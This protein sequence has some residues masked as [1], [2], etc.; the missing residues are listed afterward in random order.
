[1]R[2]ESKIAIGLIMG[3]VAV[4]LFS[5]FGPSIMNAA[6]AAADNAG[7]T[8]RR[9]DFEM[10]GLEA[11]KLLPDTIEKLASASGG[12][13]G[14]PIVRDMAP[15]GAHSLRMVQVGADNLPWAVQ[16]FEDGENLEL[17]A[18]YR[19]FT[20]KRLSALRDKP[21][22]DTPV[23][24]SLTVDGEGAIVKSVVAQRDGLFEIQTYIDGETS[25]T[26]ERAFKAGDVLFDG[27]LNIGNGHNDGI[28]IGYTEGDGNPMFRHATV[29]GGEL[30][31]EGGRL[32]FRYS[33]GP[34]FI[35]YDMAEGRTF[36]TAYLTLSK[37]YDQDGSRLYLNFAKYA[38][39]YTDDDGDLVLRYDFDE[40]QEYF[41]L[42]TDDSIRINGITLMEGR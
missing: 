18:S 6:E 23:V 7:L 27:E 8:M 25:E 9:Y 38:S 21:S 13:L 34:A 15:S 22:W 36:T 40:P 32:L 16:S 3:G 10:N 4:G 37:D 31:L 39:D 41:T 33:Y 17:Y 19:S 35:G 20:G 1:M 26:E 2:K 14:D 11:E 42:V 5:A 12:A 28:S 24:L 29:A 30:F